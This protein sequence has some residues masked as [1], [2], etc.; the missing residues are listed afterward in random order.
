[1][2]YSSNNHNNQ[3]SLFDVINKFLECFYDYQF[4]VF[5][6]CGL[7]YLLRSIIKMLLEKILYCFT[8]ISFYFI[9]FFFKT[10]K[11]LL[12]YDNF[13]WKKKVIVKLIKFNILLHKN[14]KQGKVI[15]DKAFEITK[16]KIYLIRLNKNFRRL[17]FIRD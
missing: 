6:R 17:Q 1:M 3:I 10:I 4:I 5:F 7:F 14:W 2:F 9:L 15:W 12:N 8:S 13:F 11:S 16:T